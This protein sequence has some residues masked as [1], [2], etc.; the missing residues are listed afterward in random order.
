MSVFVSSDMSQATGEDPVICQSAEQDL[1]DEVQPEN[2][3]SACE[4]TF[5][6]AN[7]AARISALRVPARAA[8]EK[9]QFG[10]QRLELEYIAKQLGLHEELDTL[11]AKDQV[12]SEVEALE[13]PAH[14][15]HCTRS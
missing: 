4:S 5:S 15:H 12:T 10:R 7:R 6:S 3:V 9:V 2:S 1:Q 13:K 14:Q 8:N 11:L